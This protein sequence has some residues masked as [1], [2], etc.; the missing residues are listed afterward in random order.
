MSSSSGFPDQKDVILAGPA[1][2]W[3]NDA[4]GRAIGLTTGRPTL[5]L[6]DLAVALRAYR[7]GRRQPVFIGC[8][9]DPNPEGL[10]RLREFQKTIP[11]SV[12][13]NQRGE[14]TDYIVQGQRDVLGMA[15][16]RVFGV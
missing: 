8:T 10:A 13:V 3:W 14:L 12:S 5:D 2:G 4:A 11:S 6:R 1:E 7:P 9:V 15:N 16:A